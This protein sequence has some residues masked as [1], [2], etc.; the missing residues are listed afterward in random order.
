[1]KRTS[2]TALVFH[3]DKI[4][5][6]LG[7]VDKDKDPEGVLNFPMDNVATNLAF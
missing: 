6:M 3:V 7:T 5:L 2:T 4:G 1:L